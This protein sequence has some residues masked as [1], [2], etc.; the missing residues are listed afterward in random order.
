MNHPPAIVLE[1]L[2]K[3]FEIG[4]RGTR[5]RAVD[6]LTLQIESGQIF[7]LLGP[8]GSGKS[9]TVK[10]V[11][12]L[13]SVTSGEC[14]VFGVPHD[15]IE[16]RRAIGYL[17]ESPYFHR[18]L[19]GRELVRF[20]GGLGGLG[21][22]RLRQRTA[23]V[24][25]WAGL[26]PA[27]N[28][29]VGTYSK[30]M[31]QRIGLA[32]ALVHDPRLVILD[33]PA[34]GMDLAGVA[35]LTALILELKAQGRTVVIVSHLLEQLEEI[36]D[37]VALLDHGRLVWEGTRADP[38][39]TSARQVLMVDPL[40]PQQLADLRVWLGERGRTLL[41]V[42]RLKWPVADAFRQHT[43]AGETRRLPKT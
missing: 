27:A 17:P 39:G 20:H 43:G 30:G 13:L 22:V 35:D 5:L 12:D 24:I 38:G 31:L 6:H 21:G 18:H 2:T 28:R 32:Q 9:T 26:E 15:R 8:N 40:T 37:R 41:G 42:E 29:R 10:L 33:E 16:A 11:L 14:F 4:V 23:E 19:T 1:G 36:C 34:A 3:D 7:G 25:A